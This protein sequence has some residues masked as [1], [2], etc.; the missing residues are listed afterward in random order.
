MKHI[1]GYVFVICALIVKTVESKRVN[2]VLLGA[3]GNLA[4]KYL[5]QGLFNIYSDGLRTG[6]DLFIYPAAT[7]GAD[8]AAPI[9]D[10]IL[11]NN[12]TAGNPG[13]KKQF[14]ERVTPYVQLRSEENYQALGESMT[15]N[16][17]A[18]N[19]EE[20]GR[21][22]YLSVPPKFFGSI[23]EYI[24]QH[25]RPSNKNA[26][27][28]V[29]V[30]KPFGVDLESATALAEGLYKSLDK[31][32]ILLVDH[33]MGKETMHALR[34]FHQTNS[35]DTLAKGKN[36]VDI[37][38]GMLETDDVK[39][40]TGFY[41]E[42]GVIRDTI[43]NHLMMMLALLVMNP[44]AAGTDQEPA[45]RQ[46]VFKLL[47]TADHKHI[48][49]LGQYETYNKH[50]DED[51]EKWGEPLR[52][53]PSNTITYAHFKI[54][55]SS[56][57]PQRWA[58]VPVHFKSGKA[59]DIRRSYIELHF[60]DGES[61]V[62]N[63]QGPTRHE[64]LSGA[65]VYASGPMLKNFVPPKGWQ[66]KTLEGENIKAVYAPKSPFAYQV[67]LRAGLEGSREH[68]VTL[69]EVLEA[70]R[71]WSPILSKLETDSIVFDYTPGEPFHEDDEG[72]E[73]DDVEEKDEL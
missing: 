5:W 48:T 60:D 41:D 54:P 47:A 25:L 46:D 6:D 14:L 62:F 39:G 9:L 66:V 59:L 22:F 30:E 70:W 61:I 57:S 43:Q 12:I 42:V 64:K 23:A 17:D 73:N 21:L 44:K 31:T 56:E 32:E 45:A 4:E 27:L 37:E 19:E 13:A 34:E 1:L 28:R 7:K 24:N 50:V 58:N 52:E 29:I 35:F 3:T 69:D 11:E 10:P 20:A 71:V 15:K 67:L 51:L 2:V 49:T 8:K 36:V 65:L 16:Q 38:V 26:W 68:F 53:K 40:R 33:Y 63:L 18:A 55:L 72:T